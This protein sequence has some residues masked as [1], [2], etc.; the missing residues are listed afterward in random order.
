MP[1]SAALTL[2]S[3]QHFGPVSAQRPGGVAINVRQTPGWSQWYFT[4]DEYHI[5]GQALLRR[6]GGRWV[7]AD[8]AFGATDVWWA[9]AP[10]CAE[11][12]A[13]TPALH[14]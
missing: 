2:G 3:T 14:G 7:V 5:G 11:F 8:F 10:L 13:V 12:R 6:E 1:H 4:G 9:Y